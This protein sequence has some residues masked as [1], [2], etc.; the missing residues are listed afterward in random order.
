MQDKVN[1]SQSETEFSE[2]RRNVLLGAT[3]VAAAAS[4]GMSGSANAAMDH[5]HHMMH[6][7]PADRQKVIDASLDCVKAGQ[8]CVQ[9][10]IDMF[11]MKDTSMAVCA[12]TV[13]EMLATCNALSQLASYDS[14]HLKDFAKICINVCKDC[15]KECDVHADKHSACKACAESCDDCIKACEDY[16]A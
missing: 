6:A 3:A 14:K 13:Q 7:I 15:K 4:M 16:I 2:S 10:C 9:H 1:Q 5:S 11:K 8:E 12:D